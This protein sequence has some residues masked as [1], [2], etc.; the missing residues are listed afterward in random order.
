MERM[1]MNP[2]YKIIFFV[3][4]LLPSLVFAAS[5]GTLGT[6]STGTVGVSITIPSLVQ[7]T[8][9]LDIAVGTVSSVPSLGVTGST[10]ACIYSN[11]QSPQVGDY[12]VTASSNVSG[13]V[14][15]AKGSG[16]NYIT[17]SA[18]WNNT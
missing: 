4:F 7:V 18:Y 15:K 5:Q 17:Y 1:L 9:L 10:S 8:G 16:S 14:F 12:F 11:L 13:S 3:N 2:L 6:T